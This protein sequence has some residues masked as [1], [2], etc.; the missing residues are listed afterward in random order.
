[1]RFEIISTVVIENDATN[2]WE[3][4]HN[5]TFTSILFENCLFKSNT[6]L[7]FYFKNIQDVTLT[8]NIFYNNTVQ[9]S[10]GRLLV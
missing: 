7:M 4:S 6:D 10:E 5:E 3:A 8:N 1:M 2:R 9:S